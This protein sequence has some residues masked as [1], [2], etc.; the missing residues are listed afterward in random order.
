VT[1]GPNGVPIL[2]AADTALENPRKIVPLFELRAVTV[3]TPLFGG[4][5]VEQSCTGVPEVTTMVFP[6]PPG[7]TAEASRTAIRRR[8]FS[9][10]IDYTETCLF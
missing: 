9:I 7:Y 4:L 8:R 6:C 10:Q 3:Q 1:G 2:F 5:Q